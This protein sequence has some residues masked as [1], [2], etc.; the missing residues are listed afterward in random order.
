M[1]LKKNCEICGKEFFEYPS[2]KKSFCSLNC[3]RIAQKQGRYKHIK[4]KN[5]FK[6]SYCGKDVHS[7]KSKKRN[8][9]YSDKIFCN[10]KCYDKFRKLNSDRVCKY[11]GKHFEALN[12]KKNAQ[13]CNDSCRRKYYAQRTMAFC[14]NCGQ[15]F[16]P[17][18]FDKQK[19]TIILDKEVKCCSEKCKREYHKKIEKIRREKISFAFTGDKHPNWLGGRYSY[20]G[21]N[22]AHQKFLARKRDGNVC[23]CC[24]ITE[25]QAKRKYGDGLEVHHKIPYIFFNGNY[26]EANKLDNL[27][28]LCRSC[29]Q[30]EEW[31][32]RREHQNDYKKY[33]ENQN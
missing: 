29:H 13:F 7:S 14:V 17:W 20:R 30:K 6:C 24:G 8:G 25:N 3:Y 26:E 33:K 15:S 32:Y 23:Q 10:R 18:N 28:S 9:E 27:I 2:K 21:K 1:S 31:R 22:W 16:Y 4:F 19:G 5:N 11:C 12:D